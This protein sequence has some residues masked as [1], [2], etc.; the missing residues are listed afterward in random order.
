[1]SG[2]QNS[3]W[4]DLQITAQIFEATNESIVLGDTVLV[5]ISGGNEGDSSVDDFRINVTANNTLLETFF[6]ETVPA[7]GY[8]TSWLQW[9]PEEK[10]L[11]QLI[12]DV[13]CNC[14]DS[15]T[16][17]NSKILELNADGYFLHSVLPVHALLPP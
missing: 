4:L 12:V 1:M 7:Y 10:G 11:N 6:Y 2:N 8:G 17:N 16:L 3:Q 5:A 14:D 9:T 13:S 15:N